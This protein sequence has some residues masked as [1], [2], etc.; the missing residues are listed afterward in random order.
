M[1]A[2]DLQSIETYAAKS[3]KNRFGE[4][5]ERVGNNQAVRLTK[6]D[7][8]AAYLVPPAMFERLV[9]MMEGESPSMARLRAEFDALLAHMQTTENVE[10]GKQL[11]DMDDAALRAHFRGPVAAAPRRRVRLR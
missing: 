4:L 6:H 11:L 3:A 2:I 7:K 9:E 10:L 8:P 5:L 1:H